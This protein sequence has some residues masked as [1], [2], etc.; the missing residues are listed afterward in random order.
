M[1]NIY[2]ILLIF[3]ILTASCESNKS[4]IIAVRTQDIEK[5]KDQ[6]KADSELVEK[7][8]DISNNKIT[9]TEIVK[10]SCE[11]YKKADFSKEFECLYFEKDFSYDEYVKQANSVNDCDK[12]YTDLK[13]KND[14]ICEKYKCSEDDLKAHCEDLFYDEDE[15]F[16]K[17]VLV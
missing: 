4:P 8:K 13:N 6:T 3:V 10:P 12:F 9:E 2:C 17:K 1:K 11:I 7:V 16:N 15:T 5:I 14:S